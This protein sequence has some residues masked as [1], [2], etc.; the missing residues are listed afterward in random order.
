MRFIGRE[1]ELSLLREAFDNDRYEGV[2]VY[3]RRRVGKTEMLKEALNRSGLTSV[4]YECKKVSEEL[5]TLGISEVI[6]RVFGIPVPLFDSFEKAVDFIFEKAKTEK[7]V[8]V[9]DE[10]PYLKEKLPGC[11]SILQSVI[12][13]H[14]NG[15]VIKL[16]LCGSYVGTMKELVS[17]SNPLYGRLSLKF[18]IRPLDY[19]DCAGFYPSFSDE[20]K[21]RLFSVFGGMPYYNQFIDET[22]TV[23]ENII[24]LV[25]SSSARLL[26]EIEQ[27]V[28]GEIS[29]MA[30]ANETF[31]AIAAGNHTFSDILNKS[32]V[33]S[34][35]TLVDVLKKLI[36]MEIVE[37]VV[38]INE[39]NGKHAVYYI[40]DRL[41]LFYYTYI[42]R[43]LSFF[44]TMPAESFYDEFIAEDF[45]TGFV[46][47][48]FEQIARQ[49][50][51]RQNRAGKIR[52]VLYDVGKYYYNDPVR[53]R[54]GEF[55][56][57]TLNRDGYDFYEVKFTSSPVT[58][59][60]VKEEKEQ[61]D[62]APIEYNRIGFFSRSGFGISD[63]DG[64]ILYSLPD[65][66]K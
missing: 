38:P 8:F 6:A 46:P 62:A 40:A 43:R 33:S 53:R 25:A 31:M 36:D 23:K 30:N 47:L 63:T 24:S 18:N 17:E 44:N 7:I 57:V 22:K 27:T 66:Y 61:L 26:N 50:L 11:D 12:D 3:G 19:Y 1:Q 48:A 54:N 58:G 4:Y 20:D 64:L 51:I 55:D 35:P 34:S 21:V 32:H 41:A 42:F 60:V 16:V 29:K 56:V 52:P 39:K 14:I 5:N 2:L 13:R 49:F 9:I 59:A 65:L 28:S 37:R 45:E 10:Y 15:S